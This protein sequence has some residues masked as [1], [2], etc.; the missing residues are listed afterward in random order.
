ME[1]SSFTFINIGDLYDALMP[2]WCETHNYYNAHLMAQEW[3]LQNNAVMYEH[4]KYH[5]SRREA[6]ELAN[7]AGV[8]T[9]VV[10]DC[11]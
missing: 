11:S 9:I 5:F 3:V 4:E 6:E 1:T 7:A 2:N 10:H 8:K